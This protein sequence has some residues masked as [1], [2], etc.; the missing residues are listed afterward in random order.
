MASDDK[1]KRCSQE[2]NATREHPEHHGYCNECGKL[3][4]AWVT[5]DKK[6]HP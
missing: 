2:L 5:R 3:I 1:C 4:E 6:L